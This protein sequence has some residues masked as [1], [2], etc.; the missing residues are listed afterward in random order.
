MGLFDENMNTGK[1]NY[2]WAQEFVEAFWSSFWT[3]LAFNFKSDIQQFKTE[4]SEN[5]RRM[6]VRAVSAIAQVE[7]AVKKFWGELGNRFPHHEMYDVGYVMAN[8]EVVH[9]KAYARLLEKLNLRKAFEENLQTKELNGRLTYLR[10]YNKKVYENNNQQ[11]IYSLILF[12]LFTENV[13]L[14]SQF[15][16]I[17]YQRRFKNLL[18]DTAQQIQYTKVEEQ[19]H[20][21]LGIKLI[22]TL[23]EEYP[24][25]F[26][27]ELND[28][29]IEE[30]NSAIEAE[31][32][33]IDWIIG[34]FNDDEHLSKD[35]LKNFVK[36]R[37]NNSLKE[38]NI[39]YQLDV[40]PELLKKTEWF[41]EDI[42]G[43]SQVDFF[44]SKPTDYSKDVQSFGLEDIF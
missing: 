3:P 19:L 28:K 42:K 8:S 7:V 35:I 41:E 21:K 9:N 11:H 43:S 20:S 12:T 25:L 1:D 16:I 37:I 15:Y 33:I 6:T 44:A 18:K 24:E 39:N 26:T 36:N 34:D 30:V 2:P 4:L 38:I 22:N 27:S 14:F 40:D 23:H 5:E 13:S 32:G 17:L 29:I 31:S 10:K